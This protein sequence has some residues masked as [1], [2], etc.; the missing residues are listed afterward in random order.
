MLTYETSVVV[1]A[2]GERLWSV[3]SDISRW[4]E[5][6]PTITRIEALGP[7]AL[8][9]GARFRVWQPRLVP[10][11]WTVTALEPQRRFVWESRVLGTRVRAEHSMYPQK[12]ESFRVVL[13]VGY[14]G[15]IGRAM[16]LAY[17]GLTRKYLALEAESLK[18]RAE[19]DAE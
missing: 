15:A 5:W 2:A 3:L 17:G 1:C 13:Q 6:T 4:S 19:S 7:A 10:A 8:E 14:C 16:G 11:I 9:I 12:S 18:R